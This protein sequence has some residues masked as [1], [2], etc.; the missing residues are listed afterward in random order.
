M[1]LDSAE[2]K[3]RQ[4]TQGHPDG[5]VRRDKKEAQENMERRERGVLWAKLG[6]LGG[7]RREREVKRASLGSLE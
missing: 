1:I 7:A 6:C 2:W 5:M 3:A 4:V